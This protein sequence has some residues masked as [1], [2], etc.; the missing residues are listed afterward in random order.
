MEAYTGADAFLEVIN[1]YGVD[2]LFFNPGID[3]ALLLETIA[4]YRTSGK[5][6]PESILCL[7]ESVA[8]HAAHG[9]YMATGKAQVVLVH[10]ELGTMQIGGAIHNAQWGKVPVIFCAEPLGPS[11]RVNWRQEPF[12]QGSMVRNFVKWDHELQKDEDLR[13]I[14]QKAFHVATSEP[15]G[16]VY[17]ILPRDI[18]NKEM[19]GT[20]DY[21]GKEYGTYIS[22][23][24]VNIDILEGVADYLIKAKNPLIITGYSGRNPLAVSELVLLAETLCARVLTAD[25]W[26]NFPNN[27]PLFVFIDPDAPW[28]GPSCLTT[29]DVILAVDYD[30]HYAAPPTVPDAKAKIIHMDMDLKKKGAPLWN[31]M[32]DLS[33]LA[34]SGVAIQALR[35]IISRKLTVLDRS[36]LKRRFEEIK[37]EH[38]SLGEKWRQMAV[39]GAR[40]APIT[41][42]WLCHCINEVITEETVIVNQTITPSASVVHQIKR[43]QPA[44]MFSC[45]GGSIGWA[46]GAGLGAKLGFPDRDVISLMGDGAFVYGCPVA[47]LWSAFFYN[48]P[49]LSIIF[50]NQAY[51]AIK[52]LFRETYNV[53]NMGADIPNPPDYAMVAQSCNAFGRTVEDPADVI[54][55]LKEALEQIRR[56]KPAVLDVLLK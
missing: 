24:G 8:M 17:L 20:Y 42:D 53:K 31:R 21:T 5:P 43:T 11:G 56:G 54:P 10:S 46:L 37:Q 45:A 4:G 18:Y 39:A 22:A 52:M 48:A 41:S 30:M 44:S 29:A 51:N 38:D 25:V 34:D 50:N 7:D 19:T 14:L 55:A 47:T 40:Q 33:I 28:G 13:E 3:N 9:N 27:H 15:H 49:F 36:R 2:H 23:P 16:P 32:P 26:M 35:N 6:S 1:R 12:D